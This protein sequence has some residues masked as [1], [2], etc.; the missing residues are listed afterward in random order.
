MARHTST[1]TECLKAR[2][3]FEFA[4]VDVERSL[5]CCHSSAP[6]RS[7]PN[8]KH[9]MKKN[10]REQELTA[11]KVAKK[12]AKEWPLPRARKEAR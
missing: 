7:Q 9:N 4:E 2:T 12:I 11:K 8:L 6:N 1:F 3:W 5:K 10:D